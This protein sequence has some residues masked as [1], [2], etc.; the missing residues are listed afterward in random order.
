MLIIV[1]RMQVQRLAANSV[2]T[3]VSRGWQD[4]LRCPTGIRLVYIAVVSGQ[5]LTTRS[6]AHY[7]IRCHCLGSHWLEYR[8]PW[9][10][11]SALVTHTGTFNNAIS[12]IGGWLIETRLGRRKSLALS[13]I[14]TAVMTFLFSQTNSRWAEILTTC[15]LANAASIMYAILCTSTILSRRHTRVKG[16][17][18]QMG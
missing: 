4:A 8:D 15:L 9:C 18:L 12:Q 11:Q 10:V 14:S 1:D 17:T 7:A 16:F 2:G 5:R 3:K 13:T 6:I